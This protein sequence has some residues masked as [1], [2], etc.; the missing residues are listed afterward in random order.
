[1]LHRRYKYYDLSWGPLQKCK[2]ICI[3]ENRKKLK[4]AKR[5][6]QAD[7]AQG[8]KMERKK[9]IIREMSYFESNKI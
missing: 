8:N 2:K 1:M 7:R 3:K 6:K 4:T 5:G 9:I